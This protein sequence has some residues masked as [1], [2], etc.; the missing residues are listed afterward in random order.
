MVRIWDL[1]ENVLLTNL[2]EEVELDPV[3]HQPIPELDITQVSYSPCGRWLATGSDL[4]KVKI[5]DALT[6][7]AEE[8]NAEA[9]A[10]AERIADLKASSSQRTTAQLEIAGRV[11]TLKSS[12]KRTVEDL[13]RHLEVL[14]RK[15]D[16]LKGEN[17]TFFDTIRKNL[18]AKLY[19]EKSEMRSDK[20]RFVL[21]R[22]HIQ[23][24]AEHLRKER[25]SLEDSISVQTNAY[26]E[27][28]QVDFAEAA[29]LEAEID[30]L[31]RKLAQKETQLASCQARIGGNKMK[32]ATVRGNYQRQF[33]RILK[34]LPVI[35]V[36]LS[37]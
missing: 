35:H 32:I 10:A 11:N 23:R 12:S 7:K 3:S 31:R 9:E 36:K 37:W 13:S 4:K 16:S 29:Q 33:T 28:L 27:E 1:R 22:D 18:E 20:Q 34:Y 24:E 30:E 8:E 26:S 19:Q 2:P 14:L 25:A 6:E 17:E 21:N 5:F 15:L